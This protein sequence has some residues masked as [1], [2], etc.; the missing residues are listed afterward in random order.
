MILVHAEVERNIKSVVENNFIK[1]PMN[2]GLF[3][4]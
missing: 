1:R 2:L 3:L 4:L